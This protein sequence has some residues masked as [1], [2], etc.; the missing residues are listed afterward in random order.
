M[1]NAMIWDG[2]RAVLILALT[3]LGATWVRGPV[4]AFLRDR[5]EPTTAAFLVDAVRP[6]ALLVALPPALEALGVSITSVLALLSTAGLAVALA[7]RD[8]LSNVASGAILLTMRPI[9][10]GDRVTVAGSTGVV[11]RIGFLIVELDTDDG[12]RVSVMNDKVLAVPMERHA[13]DGHVRL[14]LVLRLHR[15][16]GAVAEVERRVAPL[17]FGVVVMEAEHNC[18]RVSLRTRVSPAEVEVRQKQ[19]WD[20]VEACVMDEPLSASGQSG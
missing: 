6:V 14:E 10:V 12:R 2:V 7:L 17:G 15:R 18:V 8:S 13:A 11:A 3:F 19:L 9:R 5:V 4:R 20:A 1:S 16:P